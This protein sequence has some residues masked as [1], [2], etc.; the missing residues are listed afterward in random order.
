MNPQKCLQKYH[1]NWWKLDGFTRICTNFVEN[2]GGLLYESCH[3]LDDD[4]GDGMVVKK[5]GLETIKVSCHLFDDD[6][7]DDNVDSGE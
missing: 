5:R 6:G 1:Q 2:Q 4:D 7:G 3:L